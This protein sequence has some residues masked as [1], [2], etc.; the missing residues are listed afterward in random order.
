MGSYLA[1]A[2]ICTKGDCRTK[3]TANTYAV[4]TVICAGDEKVRF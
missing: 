4:K 3:P 2:G 1:L